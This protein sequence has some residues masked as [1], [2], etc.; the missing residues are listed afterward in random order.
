LDFHPDG[1]VVAVADA[2]SHCVWMI[3][4]DEEGSGRASEGGGGVT[5]GFWGIGASVASPGAVGRDSHHLNYPSDCA[6]TGPGGL[7]L[8]VADSRNDRVLIVGLDGSLRAMG[9]GGGFRV[10]ATLHCSGAG[11]M[12]RPCA[13]AVDPHFGRIYVQDQ[14]RVQA[15]DSQ[16]RFLCV[17]FEGGGLGGEG[18]A[19]HGS[20]RCLVICEGNAHRLNLFK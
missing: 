12:L 13:V 3:R 14:S 4:V 18:V 6:F 9:L 8:V 1:H 11:G 7:Q 16:G 19:V 15:F 5:E 20:Q 17:V 10:G 2:G